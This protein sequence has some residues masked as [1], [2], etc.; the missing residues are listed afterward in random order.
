[1]VPRERQD[2]T[3]ATARRVSVAS[4]ACRELPAPRARLVHRVPPELKDATDRRGRLAQTVEMVPPELRDRP[5][6]PEP[7]VR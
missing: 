5:E 1:L 6:R 4:R 7:R 2:A 3:D